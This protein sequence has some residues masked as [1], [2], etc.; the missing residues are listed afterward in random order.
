MVRIMELA[1]E[2]WGELGWSIVEWVQVK[3]DAELVAK[4]LSDEDAG[5]FYRAHAHGTNEDGA[6]SWIAMFEVAAIDVRALPLSAPPA[7]TQ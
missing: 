6:R 2:H 7:L 4:A 5:S 3:T 1:V